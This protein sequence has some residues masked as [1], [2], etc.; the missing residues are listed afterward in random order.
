MNSR[1]GDAQSR[2][3]ADS[4]ARRSYGKLVAFLAARTRDV[5]A[6]WS[7][8]IS[9]DELSVARNRFIQSIIQ[10]RFH[11]LPNA[12]STAASHASISSSELIG[13]GVGWHSITSQE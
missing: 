4:V 5:V 6:A 11:N 10:A 7:A 12:M 3:T 2:N 8:I 9:A 1:E 13:A